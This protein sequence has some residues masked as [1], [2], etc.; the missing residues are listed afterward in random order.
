MLS[1]STAVGLSAAALT[2]GSTFL[3]AIAPANAAT[4]S[5][6]GRFGSTGDF[7]NSANAGSNPLAT[8]YVNGSFDGTYTIDGTLPV[9][10][11]G[12]NL[13][14]WTINLRDEIGNVLTTFSSTA[15]VGALVGG[16]YIYP[17]YPT[18]TSPPTYTQILI[19]ENNK[20]SLELY[21]PG[22]F[23]GTGEIA[24]ITSPESFTSYFLDTSD[25]QN[26]VGIRIESARSELL[27]SSP[28]IPTPA[29][30]PGL[31]GMGVATLRKRREITASPNPSTDH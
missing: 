12:G 1:K 29:L 14:S 28:A 6:S 26:P 15:N 3:G 21:F 22:N 20:G 30:L 16:G 4:F 25:L 5:V 11:F 13:S 7:V 2:V 18:P 23:N 24:P 31:I 17:Y 19:G 9:V 27:S 10:G 8:R